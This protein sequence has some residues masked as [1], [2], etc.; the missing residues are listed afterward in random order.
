MFDKVKDSVYFR[1]AEYPVDMQK[2]V[3]PALKAL[4]PAEFRLQNTA[5][6][7]PRDRTSH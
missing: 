3:E 1:Y 5:E 4:I 6:I 7:N 2:Q